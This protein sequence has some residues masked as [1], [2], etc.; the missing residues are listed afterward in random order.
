MA[1][2]ETTWLDEKSCGRA[3][4]EQIDQLYKIVDIVK[5][6]RQRFHLHSDDR[7]KLK[8]SRA[9]SY[10]AKVEIDL[11]CGRE[12]PI[13]ITGRL[14]KQPDEWESTIVHELLHIILAPYTDAASAKAGPRLQG[15]LDGIEESVVNGLETVLMTVYRAEA[16]AAPKPADDARRLVPR[17][18]DG[19]VNVSER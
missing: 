5:A 3:T 8:F 7:L 10:L 19:P 15:V 14:L 9:H 11:H 17:Y 6:W 13:Y 1:E 2:A 18:P 12:F 16:E 4:T